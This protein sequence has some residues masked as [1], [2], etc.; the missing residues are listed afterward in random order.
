VTLA[1]GTLMRRITC[2]KARTLKARKWYRGQRGDLYP[3][4]SVTKKA[5]NWRIVLEPDCAAKTKDFLVD[6]KAVLE[7]VKR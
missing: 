1:P 6:S 5:P 4:Q 7:V 2:S 3:V